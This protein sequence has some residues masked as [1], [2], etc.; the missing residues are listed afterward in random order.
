MIPIQGSFRRRAA[1]AGLAMMLAS[2][3]GVAPAQPVVPTESAAAKK[4]DQTP[5]MII[6][7]WPKDVQALGKVMIER[8]GAPSMSSADELVWNNNGPWRKSVLHRKGL[9]QG[10]VGKDRDHLE[11]TLVYE[12]PADKVAEL[13]RFD[14][15]IMV[16]QAAGEI[17]SRADSESMNF[18]VLNLADDIVRGERS[19]QE[20]RA[21]SL[22]VKM[23]EKA[24]KTSPY[25]E[26][27]VFAA[28]KEEAAE[29][30]K[31]NP[32]TMNYPETQEKSSG[33]LNR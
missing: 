25:L 18:L 20:A 21:F 16:N 29:P 15:R 23:L 22:K 19:L 14:K 24:G 5:E 32:E 11:Q 28:K 2:A 17:S 31:M 33:E 3:A 27:F 1:G 6:Q 12:V 13:K 7:K 8:Y 9:T 30:G 10:T 26:G 4:T